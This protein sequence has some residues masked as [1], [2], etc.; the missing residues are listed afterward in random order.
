MN[1]LYYF[2]IIKNK[3]KHFIDAMQSFKG[4]L[5]RFEIFLSKVI[6]HLLN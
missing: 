6:R 2:K 1:R 3:E 5:H 4:L